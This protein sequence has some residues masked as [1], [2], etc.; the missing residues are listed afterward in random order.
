MGTE[1][2]VETLRKGRLIR[3]D[4]GDAFG[5]ALTLTVQPG[6]TDWTLAPKA[7]QDEPPQ[8]FPS[9]GKIVESVPRLIDLLVAR[10]VPSS[11]SV[12]RLALG[13]NAWVS[14]RDHEEAYGVL[15]ALLPAVEVDAASADFQYRINRPRLAGQ[16]NRGASD[17]PTFHVVGPAHRTR[18]ANRECTASRQIA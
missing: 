10:W 18:H 8:D 15:D 11:P 1:A 9:L 17:Q 14:V 3:Q 6:R 2:A 16:T 7:P 13:V 12:D 5:G 4:Q